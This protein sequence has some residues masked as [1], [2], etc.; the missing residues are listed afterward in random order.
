MEDHNQQ[1]VDQHLLV[2]NDSGEAIDAVH[3]LIICNIQKRNNVNTLIRNAFAFKFVPI[4]VGMP[5]LGEQQSCLHFERLEECKA[6]LQE[7]NVPIVG[8]E[9]M[10]ESA[11]ILTDPFT[12]SIALMP[13]NEGAGLNDRQKSACDSFLYIPQY[14]NG[15]ASLNVAVATTICLQRYSLWR[16]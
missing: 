10:A 14:G 5:K 9:I 8:I 16:G 3:F 12:S 4:I 2:E 7:R 1:Q 15:T 6:Y 11:S 13:G